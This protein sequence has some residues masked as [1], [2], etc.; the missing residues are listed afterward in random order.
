MTGQVEGRSNKVLVS[1]K[2]LTEQQREGEER[3][4][5]ERGGCGNVFDDR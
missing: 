2:D 3:Y 5:K 1:A 4:K